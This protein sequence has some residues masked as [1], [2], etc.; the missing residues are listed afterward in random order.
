L[1]V[2]GDKVSCFVTID[3]RDKEQV[4]RMQYPYSVGADGK[5]FVTLTSS[6][7]FTGLGDWDF[8]WTGS[9][10][11]MQ[12]TATGDALVFSVTSGQAE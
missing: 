7:A 3:S 9:E 11:V 4:G 6:E 1:V 8:R 12:S 2:S 5:M 10:I